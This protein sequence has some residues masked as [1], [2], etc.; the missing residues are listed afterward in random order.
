MTSL[1]EVTPQKL[2]EE[3][4]KRFPYTKDVLIVEKVEYNNPYKGR[5][6]HYEIHTN[7]FSIVN[8]PSGCGTMLVFGYW[9]AFQCYN[10]NK[11]TS[12]SLGYCM[13]LLYNLDTGHRCG[14]FITTSGADNINVNNKL[15]ELGFE[16]VSTYHNIR[17][18]GKDYQHLMMKSYVEHKQIEDDTKSEIK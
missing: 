12:D 14:V 4:Y 10:K 5:V 15:K 16:I 18:M 1:L 3:I 17:H 2:K 7:L 9:T 11:E 13:D 8:N 6:W